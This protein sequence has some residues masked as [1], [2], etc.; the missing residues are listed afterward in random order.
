MGFGDLFG[1]MWSYDYEPEEPGIDMES[2][3]KWLNATDAERSKMELSMTEEG[4][5]A[6][7][8]KEYELGFFK[9]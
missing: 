7:K 6:F 3:M 1:N 9:D 4:I 2:F 8:K 5:I